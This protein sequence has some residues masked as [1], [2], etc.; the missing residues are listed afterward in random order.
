MRLVPFTTAA[1]TA[2]ALLTA[3][4]ASAGIVA[5]WWDFA[6]RMSTPYQPSAAG[7]RTPDQDRAPAPGEVQEGLRPHPGAFEAPWPS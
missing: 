2:A 7:V 6:A 3:Q 4:P 1:A 5:D